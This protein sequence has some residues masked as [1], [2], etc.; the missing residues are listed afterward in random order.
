M[1]DIIHGDYLSGGARALMSLVKTV[2]LFIG[3]SL[4]L[5]IGRS[6]TPEYATG[7]STQEMF[8]SPYY[9]LV[10]AAILLVFGLCIIISVPLRYLYIATAIGAIG[11]IIYKMMVNINVPD[12]V[13]ILIATVLISVLSHLGGRYT[14]APVS[15]FMVT[16]VYALV[17]GSEIYDSIS[18][19]VHGSSSSGLSSLLIALLV[20]GSIALGIFLVDVV[21][22]SIDLAKQGQ[23]IDK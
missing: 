3:V 23:L 7:H 8:S 15:I 9:V 17:P 4:G 19:M 22:D 12:S 18:F 20:A 14:R 13:G 21:V 16:G 6:I 11:R 1:R 2:S 10:P 5:F